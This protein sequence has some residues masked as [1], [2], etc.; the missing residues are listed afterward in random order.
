MNDSEN[1]DPRFHEK[2]KE[3]VDDGSTNLGLKEWIDTQWATYSINVTRVSCRTMGFMVRARDES[4]AEDLA[5][6][7][8]ENTDFG[9]AKESGVEYL[10]D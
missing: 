1:I 3:A 4:E 9:Q 7:A 8:A 10:I 5:L 6:A 2:W